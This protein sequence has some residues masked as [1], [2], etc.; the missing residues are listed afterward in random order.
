VESKSRSRHST[1]NVKVVDSDV[2][3]ELT[4][5]QNIFFTLPFGA[6]ESMTPTNRKEK[7]HW[8]RL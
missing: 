1:L 4:G 3:S 6:R 8:R 7:R 2:K 5:T